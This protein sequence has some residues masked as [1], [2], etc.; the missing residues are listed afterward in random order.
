MGTSSAVGDSL[1]PLIEQMKVLRM[2]WP[3]RGWS[4]DTRLSC[5]SS[6]FSV[7]LEQAA[8]NAARK[9]LASEWTSASVAQA[10]THVRDAAQKAGGLRSGQLIF[11]TALV[12]RYFA[13]GLWW[14]WGDSMTIS[15]R[16]GLGGAEF[17]EEVHQRVR[18]AFAIEL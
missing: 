10:P 4:W 13:Y 18:D 5:A 11:A 1:T 8:H 3:K 12:G 17:R 9:S 2:D 16:V 6:S 15:L 7:D 14:P